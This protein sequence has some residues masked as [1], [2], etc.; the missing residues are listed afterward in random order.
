MDQGS[1]HGSAS[2]ENPVVQDPPA[3]RAVQI[4]S[5]AVGGAAPLALI[6]G[7]NVIEK[8]RETLE[9]ARGI[10]ELANRRGLPVV[11]K[12]S[13]DKANR[14]RVSAYRGPGLD[15]GLRVLAAVRKE[16][17]M[18]VTTDVHEPW[19]AR[20]AAEVV[21]C[22]QVPAF[23]CRQTDLI[24]ACAATGL[25]VNIKR[26]QFIAP[27]DLRHA[28]DK[29]RAFGTGGALLTERGTAFGYNNLITDMRALVQMRAFAPIVFDATHAVQ[30]P[31]AE[32]GASGGDRRFVAPLARAAVAVGIDALFVEVHPAPDRAPVD[33]PSQIDFDALEQLLGQV[34]AIEHAL[35]G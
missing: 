12:A 28:V 8:E 7:L 29:V 14:T 32:D 33:G 6:A 15:D 17:G 9:C 19:Q 26:G 1:T 4:G 18:P 30:Y 11:F 10:Q 5:V 22:L 2:A 25:P 3:H 24:K 13:F 35:H 31:G 23:L 21:D 20:V 27:L 34:T 16:T